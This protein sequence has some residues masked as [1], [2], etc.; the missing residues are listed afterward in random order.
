[1]TLSLV[2]GVRMLLAGETACVPGGSSAI[3]SATAG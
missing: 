2:I 3:F 1:M